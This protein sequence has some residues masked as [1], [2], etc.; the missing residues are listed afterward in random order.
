MEQGVVPNFTAEVLV[1]Q[2]NWGVGNFVHRYVVVQAGSG[3]DVDTGAALCSTVA[4]RWQIFAEVVAEVVAEIA[5][6][7]AAEVAAEVVAE[8][9]A[10]IVGRTEL[11]LDCGSGDP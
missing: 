1:V 5:A 7:I 2:L 11:D 3:F 4:G 10:E 9:A 8:A 6:E